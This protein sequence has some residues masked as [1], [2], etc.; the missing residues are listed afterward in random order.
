MPA[1]IKFHPTQW[2]FYHATQR[3]RTGYAF[4]KPLPEVTSLFLGV[5]EYARETYKDR[6]KVHN[7]VVMSNH[8][9]LLASAKDEEDLSAFMQL[10]NGNVARELN[11]VWDEEGSLW[12]GRRYKSHSVLDEGAI[13]DAYMYVFANTLR[14]V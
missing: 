8:Y 4:L 3:C 6:I 13:E 14:N 9:H 12:G 1:P 11:R 5:L 10:L 2:T 7:V